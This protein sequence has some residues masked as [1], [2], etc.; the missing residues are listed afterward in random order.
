MIAALAAAC[1]RPAP[2]APAQYRP[3]DESFS[4]ALPGDWKVDDSPSQTRKAAFFGPAAGP[5][6]FAE[7]I[8]VSLHPATTPEAARAARPGLPTPL[9]E[10]E[11]GGAKAWE[12]FV[13]SEFPDP[14]GPLKRVSTRVVML[15]TARGLFV[16]E[17]AWPAGKPSSRPV[18]EELLRTFKPKA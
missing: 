16:L 8:R 15:P 18:F 11:V 14:H 12:F 1:S 9:R 3:V 4:A 17:H 13:D 5:G 7:M 10:S 2:Q 6:A